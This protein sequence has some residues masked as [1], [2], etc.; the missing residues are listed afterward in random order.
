LALEVR[1][2]VGG[3]ILRKGPNP[4]TEEQSSDQVDASS[5]GLARASIA[6]VGRN[7]GQ[8]LVKTSRELFVPRGTDCFGVRQRPGVPIASTSSE[9]GTKKVHEGREREA[10]LAAS[11]EHFGEA[12]KP[13]RASARVNSG[14][15]AGTDLRREQSLGAAGH[16]DLL[17][18]RARERDVMNSMR[19]QAP[20]A[21][22]SAGGK[23]SGG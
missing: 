21:Y 14:S 3:A 19:A 17:V 22:G 10:V 1:G 13:M 2:L 8:F 16:R 4:S 9:A 7:R 12:E 5:I 6:V 15:H 23:R 11:G 20:K 18:L